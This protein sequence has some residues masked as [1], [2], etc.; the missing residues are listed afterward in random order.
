MPLNTSIP[1]LLTTVTFA[2]L[3]V[4]LILRGYLFLDT[5]DAHPENKIIT[6]IKKQILLAKNAL[7]DKYL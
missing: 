1:F 3:G 6:G 2:L 7:I 4:L 5:I